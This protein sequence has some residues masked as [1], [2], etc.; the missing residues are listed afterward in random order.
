M[1]FR[2]RFQFQS[3]VDPTKANMKI[4]TNDELMNIDGIE[5][6]IDHLNMGYAVF[7]RNITTPQTIDDVEDHRQIAGSK[8][9]SR[10]SRWQFECGVIAISIA[11]ECC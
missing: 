3:V 2:F 4:Q 5:M 7:A 9:L 8:C 6:T 11:I 1:N 10:I